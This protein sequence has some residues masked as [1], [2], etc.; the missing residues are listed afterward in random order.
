M[1][2]KSSIDT[3]PPD[4][5]VQL[6]ALLRDPRCTQLEATVLINAVIQGQTAGDKWPADIVQSIR[7]VI[8][9]SRVSGTVAARSIGAV[10][11]WVGGIAR[12]VDEISKSAVNRYA[13]RMD[14]VGAKIRQGREI[15]SMWIGQLGNAPQGQLGQL[16]NELIRN[17]AFEAA[18]DFAEG[19]DP[20]PPKALKELAIAAEKLELAASRNQDREHKIEAE[21]RKKAM[22]EAGRAAEQAAARVGVS[23]EGIA[24]IRTAILAEL[25]S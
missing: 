19:S 22:E 6:Q 4:I 14:R 25:A 7:V 9:D 12:K 16:V 18:L 24:A 11:D 1:T 10:L 23:T 2:R 15:A 20:I 21:A 8:D 13:Q 17:L 5:L 3:L